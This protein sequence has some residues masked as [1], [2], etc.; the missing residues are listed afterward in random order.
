MP[1]R[2]KKEKKQVKVRTRDL[3]PQKDP[4]GGP[5]IGMGAQPIRTTPGKT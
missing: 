4:K 2:K 5:H 3:K 1:E